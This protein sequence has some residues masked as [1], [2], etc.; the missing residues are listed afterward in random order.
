MKK[1]PAIKV[2]RFLILG[3]K[4]IV[5]NVL[6]RNYVGDKL[7]EKEFSFGAIFRGEE[8]QIS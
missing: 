4:Y 7:S 1:Q 2:L 3:E 8:G 6:W 5:C